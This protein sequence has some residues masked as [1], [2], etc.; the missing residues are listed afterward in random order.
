[1]KMQFEKLNKI[2][3]WFIFLAIQFF[4][5]GQGL[6]YKLEILQSPVGLTAINKTGYTELTFH[7]ENIEADFIGYKIATGATQADAAASTTYYDCSGF[8]TPNTAALNKPVKAWVGVSGADCSTTVI[9]QLTAGT[10]VAVRS[11]GS[12]DCTKYG[13]K[14]VDECAYSDPVVAQVTTAVA[15]PTNMTIQ[16]ISGYYMLTVTGAAGGLGIFY[17]PDPDEA[18]YK[19]I[20]DINQYDGFCPAGASIIQIG[21]TSGAC[22]TC[23]CFIGNFTLTTGDTIA[24][25]NSSTA[26]TIFPWSDP[27][28]VVVP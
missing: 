26:N 5:C 13:Y 6:T 21:G 16:L 23:N 19:A 25:R 27:V 8:T 3:I 1:M 7:A 18:N 14:T 12:R 20:A 24:L 17:S 4:F 15:A 22:T 2:W 10:W 28:S 9:G 11:H